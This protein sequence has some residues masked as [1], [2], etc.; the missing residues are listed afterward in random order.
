MDIGLRLLGH[1]D[2][3]LPPAMRASPTLTWDSRVKA[4]S[5]LMV[6]GLSMF[7]PFCA[8]LFFAALHVFTDMDFS[9]ACLAMLFILFLMFVQHMYFYSYGRLE[10]TANAYSLQAFISYVT[11]IFYTGGWHS[12]VMPLLVCSPLIAFMTGG[13]RA[14]IATTVA[15]FVAVVMF[16]NER[17]NVKIISIIAPVENTE[18]VGLAIWLMVLSVLAFFL[19]VTNT[20]ICRQDIRTHFERVSR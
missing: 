11:A 3:F 20:L 4:W 18:T 12:P 5:M 16:F 9:Q 14:G 13:Y 15:V 17:F 8:L 2:S 10:I 6:L 19:M 7:I 1:I